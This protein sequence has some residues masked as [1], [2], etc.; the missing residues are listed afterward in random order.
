[1]VESALKKGGN[2]QGARMKKHKTAK[3]LF[4]SG[5]GTDVGKTY[6]ATLVAKLLRDAGIDAGYYK[7][8]ASGVVLGERGCLESD[9]MYVA[10]ASGLSDIHEDM[11]SFS[12]VS[13]VSPHLAARMEGNPVSLDVV[14]R[15]FARVCARHDYVIVEGCGGVACPLRFDDRVI[16]LADVVRMLDIPILLVA[17][18]GLGTLNALSTTTAYLERE[19]LHV[20]GVILNR[21]RKGDVMHEDNRAMAEALCSVPV[22]ACVPE[23]AP[24][25]VASVDEVKDLFVEADF[26]SGSYGETGL[27]ADASKRYSTTSRLDIE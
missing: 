14:E 21:F 25:L 17:D 12:Y 19:R 8:A 10:R 11:V 2:W 18:A 5:T 27:P 22:V 23:G 13:A 16:M 26:S 9:A 15:D 1:M 4:I 7:P 6:C 3:A 24:E 20:A